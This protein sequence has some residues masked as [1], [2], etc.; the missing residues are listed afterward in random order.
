MMPLRLLSLIPVAW[1]A[2]VPMPLLAQPART[3]PPAPAVATPGGPKAQHDPSTLP[4]LVAAMRERILDAARTGDPEKLRIAL[5]RNETP[6]VLVRGGKGDLITLLK[7]KSSD[8]EGREVLARLVNL[9]EGPFA[10]IEAGRRQEMYVWPAY[11]EMM[12]ETLKPED[13]VQLYRAVPAATVRESLERRKYLGDRLGLGPDG[14]WH[15][16]L[17]GE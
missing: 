6:P 16:F 12:W 11:A 15:Y 17:N 3:A 9:L 13:W 5:E 4:H 14:T 2:L 10:R 7:S 8:A 1:A